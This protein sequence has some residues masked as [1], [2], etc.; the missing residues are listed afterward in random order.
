MIRPQKTDPFILIRVWTIALLAPILLFI[1]PYPLPC[2][3]A[4]PSHYGRGI[5][6]YTLTF[7]LVMWLVLT[8]RMR[9][10]WWNAS[11]TC[12]SQEA[13]IFLL[14]LSNLCQCHK[15]SISSLICCLV[16]KKDTHSKTVSS[17]EP[18]LLQTIFTQF[19]DLWE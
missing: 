13:C 12:R 7:S 9:Q 4:V 18:S 17:T 11:S 10:N 15:K 6:P 19:T 5:V 8:N 14:E 3:S 1:Y 2:N 16:M